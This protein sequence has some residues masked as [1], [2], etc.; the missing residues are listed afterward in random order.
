MHFSFRIDAPGLD[1]TLFLVE[2]PALDARGDLETGFLDHAG[3]ISRHRGAGFGAL[4]ARLATGTAGDAAAEL[5]MLAVIRNPALVLDPGL[6]GRIAAAL[7]TLAPLAG[8]W[9]IAAAGGLTP[10][11]A[12]VC[13]LYSSATPFLPTPGAPKPLLDPLPDLYLSDAAWLRRLAATGPT[14]PDSGFEIA[15]AIQGYLEGRIAVFLPGLT[16]GID[17]ALRPRDLV[18]LRL[19]LGDRFAA[20]L[21]GQEIPTLMGPVRI[22]PD[23]RDR[24]D[25]RPP[26][27]RRDLTEAIDAAIAPH[28]AP[29][30]LS[31]VTRTR[32]QRPHLLER[33]LTSI[34]RARRDGDRIEV[35]LSSDAPRRRCEAAL[36]DLKRKFVNLTLRLRHNPARGHSRVTN[37]LAGLRAARHD[38][39]AVMDDDDYVDLFAFEEM[40]KALFLGARPVMATGAEVHD[41]DWAE[42][43]SGRHILA[44][45]AERSRYPA[46]GW[47]EMFGGVNRLPVCALVLPR[48]A[49]AARLDAFEFR[50]DLSEDYALWLLVLTDPALP[51]IVELPGAFGHISLR[52][53]EGHS[54]TMADR[55]PWVRDIALYLADL[56][57]RPGVAGP[58]K[59]ALL[60]G[61]AAATVLDAKTM[62]EMTAGVEQRD[63]ELR[64]LR[65]EVARLRAARVA[66]ATEAA[67][68]APNAPA[69]KAGP[70]AARDH[71]A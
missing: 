1:R 5:D 68:A 6:P 22:E 14:L 41:E 21:P 33:L 53:G 11:G 31:I 27:A 34:T 24:D 66:E 54:V 57:A 36:A 2:R 69:V 8:R 12:R 51:E 49:L 15:L 44:R 9:S 71:A 50:H 20:E 63:R 56:A 16:A 58:G 3:P 40:G 32:F 17:G 42:T 60:S 59:W 13:A 28:C 64:L 26:A 18:K 70:A 47:R 19:D 65:Q 29:L 62:A 30:S 35:V 37:L 4:A 48:A 67:H 7:G 25:P 10:A 52:Q 61:S 45:S 55:R 46:T 38:H 43:P 23:R 39:V